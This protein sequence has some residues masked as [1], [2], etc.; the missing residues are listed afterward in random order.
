MLLQ[1]GNQ[2]TAP[3]YEGRGGRRPDMSQRQAFYSS[4][5]GNPRVH[6]KHV[7]NII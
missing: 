3:L 2:V 4:C 6:F 1:T 7:S 5:N